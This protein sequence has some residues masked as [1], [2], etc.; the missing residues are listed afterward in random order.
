MLRD[1]NPTPFLLL[2]NTH[3]PK[4]KPR[5]RNFSS[6]LL[7]ASSFSSRLPSSL[8]RPV[9]GKPSGEQLMSS[10]LSSTA[11][12]SCEIAPAAFVPGF[13]LLRRRQSLD[14]TFRSLLLPVPFTTATNNNHRDCCSFPATVAKQDHLRQ[15]FFLPCCCFPAARKD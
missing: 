7:L 3:T 14:C 1:L 8:R 13:C 11:A 12:T 2:R 10:L 6:L 5:R 9:A 4:H 15:P